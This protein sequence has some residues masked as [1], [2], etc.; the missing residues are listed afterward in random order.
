M[1]VRAGTPIIEKENAAQRVNKN[2]DMDA[3][4]SQGVDYGGVCSDGEG[5]T[6]YN[7]FVHN[8]ERAPYDER[9]KSLLRFAGRKFTALTRRSIAVHR[10][11]RK[12]SSISAQY[13]EGQQTIAA[14][15]RA[16]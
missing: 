7:N 4:G 16:P 5:S 10:L 12:G 3:G 1:R 14:R 9:G 2:G 6:R 13:P 8:F 11:S 15:V